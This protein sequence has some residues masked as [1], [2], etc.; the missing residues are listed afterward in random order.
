MT[1]DNYYYYYYNMAHDNY[2]YYY[3]NMAHLTHTA[4]LQNLQQLAAEPSNLPQ[5]FRHTRAR[6]GP[7][8]W[9]APC[10]SA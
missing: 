8:R 5:A 1:H 6:H 2:Y 4:S 3:Y 9:R 10:A 7:G